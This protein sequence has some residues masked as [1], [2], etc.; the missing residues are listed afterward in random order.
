MI[1]LRATPWKNSKSS[2]VLLPFSC[3][4]HWPHSTVCNRCSQI[5]VS[6]IGFVTTLFREYER[7]F[8]TQ[9]VYLRVWHRYDTRT[10]VHAYVYP[11]IIAT[12]SWKR[13]RQVRR[14]PRIKNCIVCSASS[15]FYWTDQKVVKTGRTS[16]FTL[17]HKERG[18]ARKETAMCTV[19][20]NVLVH[21]TC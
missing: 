17:T 13:F 6:S 2:P 1:E 10:Y 16:K 7:S 20:V 4:R 11:R 12:R 8:C 19:H 9:Y 3:T 14:T 18:R 21:E 5:F 15:E